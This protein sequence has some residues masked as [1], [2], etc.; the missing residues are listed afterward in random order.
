V[1]DQLAAAAHDRERIDVLERYVAGAVKTPPRPE[2]MFAV[3][4]LVRRG[5]ALSIEA[6]ATLTGVARRQLERRFQTNVGLS[7]KAF[8]RLLR[9]N[10]AGRL[11]LTGRPLADIAASCGYVDQAHMSNDFRRLLQ[12]SPQEWQRLAGTL[13]PLFVGAA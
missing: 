13:G 4:C 11:A 2:V 8:A 7:P 3:D 10:R 5:G 1:I 12:Q 9:V 6:L